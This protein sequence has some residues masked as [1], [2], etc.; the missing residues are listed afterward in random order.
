MKKDIQIPEVKDVHVAAIFVHN[1][2]LNSYEWNI[3][4]L[5][6]Q[7][8]PIETVLIVS[9]GN[10]QHIR[11]SVLRKQVKV[12]PAKSFVKIEYLHDDLL[13]IENKFM[14]SYFCEG[15]LYDKSFIFPA[16]S[17]DLKNTEQLPLI[18]EKGVLAK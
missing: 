15:R 13:S 7:P 2:T 8:L 1:E 4:L 5:N 3:Y 9:K 12:V 14:V 17:I 18:S 10:D 6:N 11:T 16:K